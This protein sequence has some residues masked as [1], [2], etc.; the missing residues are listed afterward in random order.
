M[1]AS[2]YNPATGL[3]VQ[4]SVPKGARLYTDN[5]D[6]IIVCA[7]CGKQIRAGDTFTSRTILTDL[8]FGFMVCPECYENAMNQE[9][10]QHEKSRRS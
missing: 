10:K 5:L 8:G 6:E 9:R 1:S 3:T 2:K 7:D 4:Y